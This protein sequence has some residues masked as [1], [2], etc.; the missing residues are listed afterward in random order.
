MKLVA[1]YHVLLINNWKEIV[2]EQLTLM[3]R[4]GLYDAVDQIKIGALGGDVRELEQ[5][6][7][8]LK[9]KMN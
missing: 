8:E 5:E 7:K 9:A 1:Y 3:K 6:I 4:S 2:T